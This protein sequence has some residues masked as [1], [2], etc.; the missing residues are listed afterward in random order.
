MILLEPNDF[1]LSPESL[2]EQSPYQAEVSDG[3]QIDGDG[4][5]LRKVKT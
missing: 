3:T 4:A 2:E 5:G 1:V